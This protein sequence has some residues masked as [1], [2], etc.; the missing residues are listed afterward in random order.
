[1]NIDELKYSIRNLWQRKLRSSLTI[2]SILIGITAIFA[3]ISFGLGIQNYINT[4]SKEMGADK[5]F[6]LSKGIGTPGTDENFFLSKDEIDFIK[7]INGVKKIEGIY[8]KIGEVK[9]RNEKKYNFLV[10]YNPR[11]AD[12]IEETFTVGII[13]G[14]QLRKGDLNKVVLGYD[15]QFENK[16]FKRALKL[17]DKI[18]LDGRKVEVVGFFDKIG[19]PQ[20]DSSVYITDNAFEQFY[21]EKKEKFGY[22][23]LQADKNI[24]PEKLAEKIED[25]LRKYKGQEKGKEDFYV[26]T[27]ADL[28]E[29][30]GAI[31][32]IINGVLVLIALISVLVA[33]VNIMNTMY[34]AILERTKEI[35]IM[36]AIGARNK[37]ILLIFVFESA[38]LGFV[39]GILG[40][41]FGYLVSSAA[42][43]IAA[44]SGYSLLKPIFPWYLTLGCL[45]FSSSVG[46][47]SGL[48]PAIQ[49]SKLQPVDSLRYE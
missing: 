48:L 13:K 23:V 32:V 19:N 8:L 15:Y 49:A 35:G 31:I 47:A 22:A 16:I 42:G 33:S 36:K 3:L 4:L 20:D 12:F 37:E 9:L 24:N 40:I 44:T 1:M 21:P 14:R 26:Q 28:I 6:V 41:F 7:K 2:V 43:R 17:G 5:L 39:G 11:D 25:K 34:T 30:F 10:A 29:T 38:L 18:E 27:F 45:L 46:F